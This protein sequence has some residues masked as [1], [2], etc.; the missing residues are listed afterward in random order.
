MNLHRCFRVH[1]RHMKVRLG[2]VLA[3][4]LVCA[5][6]ARRPA[7]PVPSRTAVTPAAVPAE[8]AVSPASEQLKQALALAAAAKWADVDAVLRDRVDAQQLQQ[9]SLTEQHLAL[10]LA[11]NAAMVRGEPRRSLSLIQR[12]C[13]MADAGSRDWLIRVTAANAAGNLKDAAFALTTL[14]ERWPQQLA[15]AQVQAEAEGNDPI[16]WTLSRLGAADSDAERY[17]LL[18][19]L[20]R[21]HFAPEPAN[22]SSWWRS[23]ALLQLARGELA[24]AVQTLDRVSDPHIAI[25]IWADKRFDVVRPEFGE[26]LQIAAVARR[27]MQ[28]AVLRTQQSPRLLKPMNRLA[29]LLVDSLQFQQALQVTDTAIERQDTQGRGAWSDY[30]RQYP[31]TLEARARA[32]YG[33]GRWPAA[34]TQLEAASR[35][36]SGVDKVTHVINLADAYN[37]AGRPREALETL[38]RALLEQAS[39]MGVMQFRLEQFWA[40]LQLH[41]Q[42]GADRA[43]AFLHER[44]LDAPGVYQEALLFADRP[45]EGAALLISRLADVRLRSAALEAVQDYTEGALSP[46]M[47]ET[48]RRWEALIDRPDVHQAILRVGRVDRY[49]LV[50]RH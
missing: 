26:Q 24:S 44:Q 12:A 16:E 22:A 8:A 36:E 38:Q 25:S 50:G 6:A 23:L 4:L 39:P 33:L 11:A 47:L 10:M 1:S 9:L 46:V 49:A 3:F 20:R 43:L 15:Q 40:D 13:A 5:C 18:N 14:A 21:V 37:E 45:E 27:G 35:V 7:S 31:W 30:D 29:A 34:L 2:L 48:R 19:T 41:D 32:L 42:P 28:D 17:T